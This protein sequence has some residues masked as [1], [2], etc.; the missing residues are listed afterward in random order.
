MR[1]TLKMELTRK[2]KKLFFLFTFLGISSTCFSQVNWE[3]KAGIGYSNITAKDRDGNKADPSAVPGIYFGLGAAIHISDLFAFQPTLTYARRGF[4]QKGPA[5]FLGWGE[6]FEA[7][8][9]YVELPADFIYM[10]QIGPGNL[11]IAAGPYVGYGTGGKWTTTGDVTIG[12]IRIVGN[13]DI[14]FQ[15]DN[16]YHKTMN[17]HVYARPWD[18]G[19]HFRLGYAL[20]HRYALSFE[21]QQGIANLQPGWGD[22]DPAGKIRSRSFGVALAYQF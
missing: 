4:S 13:G 14:D 11:L 8:V 20:Y 6:G 21:M 10:P 1:K 9:S 22:N 5:S 16:S 7:K 12:D 2:I 15:D 18:Y 17:H 19:V 3:V